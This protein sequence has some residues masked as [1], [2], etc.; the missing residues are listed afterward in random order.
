MTGSYFTSETKGRALG[1]EV[2]REGEVGKGEIGIRTWR[3][4]ERERE[5]GQSKGRFGIDGNTRVVSADRFFVITLFRQQL[6]CFSRFLLPIIFFRSR[7]SLLRI[8]CACAEN[9]QCKEFV[10]EYL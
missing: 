4:R 9:L 3:G 8:E 6:C 1:G 7:P 5:E 2:G 10:V